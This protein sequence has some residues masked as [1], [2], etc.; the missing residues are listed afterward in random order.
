V[1]LGWQLSAA[2]I[3]DGVAGSRMIVMV[4]DGVMAVGSAGV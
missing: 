1:R 2:L 4:G 3:D